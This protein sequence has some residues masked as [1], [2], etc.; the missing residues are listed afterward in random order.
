MYR[1][2]PEGE[3]R[4]FTKVPSVSRVFLPPVTGE[5]L[6][7]GLMDPEMMWEREDIYGRS[8]VSEIAH[9]GGGVI[10][11][12]RD[13]KSTLGPVVLRLK[14]YVTQWIDRK[15]PSAPVILLHSF[16]AM[17]KCHLV[18][19]FVV[20]AMPDGISINVRYD[21]VS[22]SPSVAV[23]MGS[24]KIKKAH[25]LTL[26]YLAEQ[27]L[28]KAQKTR[29]PVLSDSGARKAQVS[30]RYID[31][32]SRNLAEE[33]FVEPEVGTVSDIL[34]LQ[35]H[36]DVEHLNLDEYGSSTGSSST[37]DT[38]VPQ[39]EG[40]KKA[41]VSGSGPP[42]NKPLP[43]A[44][45]KTSKTV[46]ATSAGG[47]LKLAPIPRKDSDAEEPNFSRAQHKSLSRVPLFES[48]E[49][50]LKLVSQKYHQG[51]FVLALNADT[52]E[53][54]EARVL[55]FIDG[56]YEVQ[57]GDGML[58][59]CDEEEMRQFDDPVPPAAR[60]P[61][62]QLRSS[63]EVLNDLANALRENDESFSSS[64][65]VQGSGKTI[66]RIGEVLGEGEDEDSASSSEWW[67]SSGPRSPRGGSSASASPRSS[68]RGSPR[69]SGR[70]APLSPREAHKLTRESSG[71][72]SP[73]SKGSSGVLTR[74]ASGKLKQ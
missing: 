9:V 50:R 53:W 18:S 64:G 34:D 63:G 23:R 2:F 74:N 57:F 68:N 43:V 28:A 55:K 38:V 67:R 8:K 31:L 19:N 33:S 3:C 21:E 69:S 51:A 36:E 39:P 26:M 24:S 4:G 14:L 44:T 12:V 40:G 17:Q 27:L 35:S 37:L 6:L 61:R 41:P 20:Q 11:Y 22:S 7:E 15:D 1:I 65:E 72:K 62:S 32:S 48:Q 56:L 13:V 45:S 52:D 16:D 70:D 29:N 58:Q 42:R 66:W 49:R 73:R 25:E 10:Q 71:R 46:P 47:R 54:E 5:L 60:A 30:P 59:A